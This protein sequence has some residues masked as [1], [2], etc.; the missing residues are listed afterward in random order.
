[1]AVFEPSSRT[2]TSSSRAWLVLDLTRLHPRLVRRSGWPRTHPAR[3]P[4]ISR[5]SGN[6]TRP[7][8]QRAVFM[9]WTI[10]SNNSTSPCWRA[11]PLSSRRRRRC[12]TLS[13]GS[14][15][16]R[17]RARKSIRTCSSGRRA[18]SSTYNSLMPTTTVKLL[19]MPPP[20][21][22]ILNH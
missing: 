6:H 4:T 13:I 11:R 12:S 21:W 20:R 19:T 7:A 15:C 5:G 8:M 14:R 1:M 2:Q 9:C 18:L 22:T 16:S 3:F 10:S 17:S